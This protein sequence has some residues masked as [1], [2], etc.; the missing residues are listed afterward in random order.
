MSGY[1]SERPVPWDEG[2]IEALGNP[3]HFRITPMAV[4]D[5]GGEAPAPSG[6][7]GWEPLLPAAQP[8]P[9]QPTSRWARLRAALRRGAKA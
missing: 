5:Y 7:H 1:V 4:V 9:E 2:F 8:L 3:N 6:P